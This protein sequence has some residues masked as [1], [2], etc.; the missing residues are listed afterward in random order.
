MAFNIPG[1][2]VYTVEYREQSP[3]PF[4]LH[5]LDRLALLL[6][7]FDMKPFYRQFNDIHKMCNEI[8]VST[9]H[10]LKVYVSAVK[11]G[12]FVVLYGIQLQPCLGSPQVLF[13]FHETKFVLVLQ[14]FLSVRQKP[15]LV[16]RQ[17]Y[18]LT[19]GPL[20]LRQQIHKR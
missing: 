16:L 1:F 12:L 20:N 11:G 7:M 2:C 15:S 13:C 10:C 17:C 5:P 14:A 6:H 8:H 19:D 3:L 4:C 18:G 9:K